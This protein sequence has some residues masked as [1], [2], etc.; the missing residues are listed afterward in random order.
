MEP[1]YDPPAIGGLTPLRSCRA[2]DLGSDLIEKIGELLVEKG[3]IPKDAVPEIPKE[4]FKV[5]LADYVGKKPLRR[6]KDNWIDGG[7]KIAVIHP[8]TYLP[9]F[10]NSS[11]SRICRMCDGDHT[12]GDIITATQAAWPR[13]PGKVLVQDLMK[14]LLLLEE[15][16]LIEFR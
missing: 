9:F 16:D 14:A 3:M 4:V 5:K 8:E 15:L 13:V 7:D 1:E 11:C 6:Y 10:M 12:V 2:G